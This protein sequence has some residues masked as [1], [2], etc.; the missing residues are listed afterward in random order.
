MTYIHLV[1][2]LTLTVYVFPIKVSSP[3]SQAGNST[4]A[5]TAPDVLARINGT[6]VTNA[7]DP[8]KYKMFELGGPGY[9]SLF[10]LK[11]GISASPGTT[12]SGKGKRTDGE[13]PMQTPPRQQAETGAQSSYTRGMGGSQGGMSGAKGQGSGG[14]RGVDFDLNINVPAVIPRGSP[15]GGLSGLPTGLSNAAPGSKF[16]GP[17]LPQGG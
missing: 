4:P 6:N 9:G 10:N 8:K 17:S 15:N 7:I 14:K 1:V 2:L 12:G 16:G 5:S 11:I 3:P 13:S